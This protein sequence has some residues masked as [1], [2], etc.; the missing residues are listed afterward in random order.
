[1]VFDEQA[2]KSLCP[3]GDDIWFWGNAVLNKTKIKL[4]RKALGHPQTVQ[5]TQ[6]IALSRKNVVGKQNDQQIASLLDT[7][8]QIL[9]RLYG[10]Q[11]RN[12]YNPLYYWRRYWQKFRCFSVVKTDSHK[13]FYLFGIKVF[14]KARKNRLKP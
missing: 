10:E 11:R 4:I 8:P 2:F 13:I 12:L 7:Y 5:G 3:T 1:M 14:R 6:T 9:S